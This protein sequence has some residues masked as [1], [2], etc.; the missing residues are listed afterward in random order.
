MLQNSSGI[1]SVEC[2][3]WKAKLCLVCERLPLGVLCFGFVGVCESAIQIID[4]GFLVE[5]CN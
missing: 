4:N 3:S 2:G 1:A 5:I